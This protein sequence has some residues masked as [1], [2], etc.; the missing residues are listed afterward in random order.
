MYGSGVI[1]ATAFVHMLSPADQSLSS[2]CAPDIFSV[3]YTSWAGAICVSA[4]IILFT[5]QWIAARQLRKMNEKE[6]KGKGTDLEVIEKSKE[7]HEE[8]D[9]EIM[10]ELMKKK[11][12]HLAIYLLELGIASHS[13]IIGILQSF[14]LF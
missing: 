2:P 3:Q 5:T 14:F 4:I 12:Q 13:I 11:E 1:M 6:Q 7:T 9:H 10:I 8:D